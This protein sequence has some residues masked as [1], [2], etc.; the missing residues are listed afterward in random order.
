MMN[1]VGVIVIIK[2]GGCGVFV[3]VCIDVV[4][5]VIVVIIDGV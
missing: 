5:D 2:C 4:I 1:V 3:V